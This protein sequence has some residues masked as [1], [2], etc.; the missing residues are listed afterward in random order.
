MILAE[1]RTLGKKC[2]RGP[3]PPISVHPVTRTPSAKRNELDR[4]FVIWMFSWISSSV[5]KVAD[6]VSVSRDMST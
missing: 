3:H 5:S 1:M 4:S 2:R 6:G